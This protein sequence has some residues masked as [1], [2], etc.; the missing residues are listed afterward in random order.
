[1]EPVITTQTDGLF[2]ILP[3]IGTFTAIL[4]AV[5]LVSMLFAISRRT[6]GAVGH[7]LLVSSYVYGIQ[8][9]VFGLAT[10]LTIWGWPAVI[11]GIFMAGMGVVPIGMLASA[12]N[13]YW[14][15]FL[16]LII[17]A[18]LVFGVR[19]IGALLVN[20]TESHKRRQELID[21]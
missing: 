9:W 15:I 17:N 6:R 8:T 18:L 1:M 20:T 13:G 5:N 11:I 14:S 16:S 3:F 12:L 4:F 2:T 21:R 7:I 19:I 10:T